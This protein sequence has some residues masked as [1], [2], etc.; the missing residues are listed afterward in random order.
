M[1]RKTIDIP[2]AKLNKEQQARF[3]EMAFSAEQLKALEANRDEYLLSLLTVE[4][5][6]KWRQADTE[7]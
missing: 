7:K 3:Y 5:E 6:R 4:Y 2:L 1:V